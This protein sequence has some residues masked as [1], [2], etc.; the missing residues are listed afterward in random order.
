[1]ASVAT[2]GFSRYLLVGVAATGAHYAILVALVEFAGASS[3]PSAVAGAACGAL[4]AY[5]GNRRF[6]F[7]ARA[8]HTR[9]LPRFLAVAAFGVAAS[10]AIVWIGSVLAGLH[11][12]AAQVLATIF[13]LW[14]GFLLNHRW[15]FA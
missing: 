6:T 8:P 11:Y 7:D 2:A 14:S 12:L 10:G 3:A 13:V 15:S 9:A 4:A 1:M 5:A